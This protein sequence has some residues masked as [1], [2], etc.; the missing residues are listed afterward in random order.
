MTQN[1]ISETL[2]DILVCPI[3]HQTLAYVPEFQLLYNPRL[4]KAYPIRN[5]IP[6]MLEEDSID[7]TEDQDAQY[8]DKATRYTGP[9][10]KHVL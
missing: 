7:V 9:R 5:S 3:D 8:I 10:E 2:L 4:K 6:V 1:E